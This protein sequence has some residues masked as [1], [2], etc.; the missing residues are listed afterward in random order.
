MPSAKRNHFKTIVIP[1]GSSTHV[2]PIDLREVVPVGLRMPVAWTDAPISFSGS[3][4]NLAFSSSDY[5]F[6][7]GSNSRI[8]RLSP[9][10]AF[11]G[12]QLNE[13]WFDS[14]NWLFVVSG[15]LSVG[16]GG[17]VNQGAERIIT[18]TLKERDYAPGVSD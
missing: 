5:S 11:G 17:L 14:I 7:A 10:V 15:D 18:L 12:Y 9:V 3:Q 13:R 2:E 16:T 4:T 6:L 8:F 1:S